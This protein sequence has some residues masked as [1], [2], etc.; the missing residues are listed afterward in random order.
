MTATINNPVGWF[1][2]P[3]VDMEQSKNFYQQV[4]QLELTMMEMAQDLMALF[5]FE[6]QQPGCGGALV[7]GPDAKP[8]VT[9]T[10]IYFQTADV[11]P[12]LKRVASAGGEVLLPKTA[13][14]EHGFIG[15]FLDPAGNKLGV[16]SMV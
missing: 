13:I 5:P 12:V 10:T 15:M 1:E 14:G 9:G 11:A 6:H 7:L 16:H 4:F 8:S 2:I 3:V